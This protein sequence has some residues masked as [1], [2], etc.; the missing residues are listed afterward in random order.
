MRDDDRDY[1]LMVGWHNRPHVREWWNCDEPAMTFERARAEYFDLTLPNSSTA[2][3]IVECF[4][5]PIGYCQFYPWHDELESAREIGFEPQPGWWGIDIFIGDPEMTGKGIGTRT[6]N[7]L[8]S[9]LEHTKGATAVALTTSI[10]NRQ[11]IRAYEKAGF[12]PQVRV[13][14]TDTKRGQRVTSWLM[15]RDLRT[16]QRRNRMDGLY[17]DRG[18]LG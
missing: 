4:T 8:C 12:S 15:V 14:D 16:E 17:A 1:A 3:C 9:Y 10:E 7:I 11:A 13:L 18:N 2:A 5:K 6:V